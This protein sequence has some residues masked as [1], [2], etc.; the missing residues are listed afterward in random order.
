MGA[1]MT[2]DPPFLRSLYQEARTCG[3]GDVDRGLIEL[4][5]RVL[6]RD[7][8]DHLPA[9]R[10]RV[11]LPQVVAVLKACEDA[12]DDEARRRGGYIACHA[13]LRAGE[14]LDA[15]R[16]RDAEADSA[17][18][19]P[20]GMEPPAGEAG[21]QL[22]DRA[23]LSALADSPPPAA[24]E[25]ALRALAEATKGADPLRRAII[26]N[27][28]VNLLKARK[29]TSPA[30]LVDA[31][32]GTSAPPE[33]GGQGTV[34][35]LNDPEPW[36]EPVDG[37]VLLDAI[38]TVLTRYVV[39]PPGAA[40]AM[41]LWVLHTHLIDILQVSPILGLTSPQKRCGKSTLLDVLRALARRA[42]GASNITAAAVF[43]VV[44]TFTPTLLIDEADTF[45][46]EHEELRGILNAGHTRTGAHVV[47]TVGDDFK[48]RLFRTSCAKAI[49][50]IGD[51]PGTIED[52]AIVVRM[53]R[54]TPSEQVERLRRDR[55]D[56]ELEPLRR[57]GARWAADHTTAIRDA[58]SDVPN[59]LNDR[60]ADNWR[61]LLAIADQAGGDWPGRARD[62]ARALSGAETTEDSDVRVQLLA[63]VRCA[64]AAAPED[65]L[66]TDALLTYLHGLRE[67]PWCEWGRQRKP[68]TPRGL[69]GLLKPFAIMSKTVRLSATD[70]AKGYDRADFEDAF[71]RYLAAENVTASQPAPGL[72][73]TSISHASQAPPCDGSGNA[74][75][76]YGDKGCDAVTGT[77][78]VVRV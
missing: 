74:T 56:A 10:D 63:D 58:D 52:R 7:H 5:A 32:L 54:R 76:P 28:A 16:E 6:A 29:V 26:R 24:V 12:G 27:A 50:A 43:R 67:R 42:V 33:T 21:S 3:A 40:V 45:L 78:E 64:F 13:A 49:A 25:A 1:A 8:A 35:T 14:L 44:E 2:A 71:S 11:V 66:A 41:A 69:A 59:A 39:L 57:Q 17:S 37:A 68:L 46:R 18:L 30:A 9:A 77:R 23:G 55:M 60:A 75:S 4:L 61:P 65:R 70:T 38:A 72:A 36:P 15:E 48:P 62:A 20:P 34:L 47:R 53:K 31:A 51:L 19:E 73:E 22:L